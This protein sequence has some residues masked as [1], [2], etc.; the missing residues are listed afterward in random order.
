[1][2]KATESEKKKIIKDLMKR[3]QMMSRLEQGHW[4]EKETISFVHEILKNGY[5]AE[6]P[7]D[8]NLG[9]SSREL[10]M[11]ASIAASYIK[12]NIP[13]TPEQFGYNFISIVTFPSG[14]E[15]TRYF[16][17]YPE[18]L[19]SSLGRGRLDLY[20]FTDRSDSS[21]VS[22]NEHAIEVAIRKAC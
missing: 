20:Y 15:I 22:G 11:Y 8:M 6:P 9:L 3:N 12:G 19:I 16:H 21:T 18:H 14:R 4:M 17:G 2:A 5:Y 7:L 10:C 13:N 1:M